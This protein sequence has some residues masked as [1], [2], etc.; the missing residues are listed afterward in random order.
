MKSPKSGPYRMN[1]YPYRSR[2]A[3]EKQAATPNRRDFQT[4]CSRCPTL[5]SVCPKHQVAWSALEPSSNHSN[6]HPSRQCESRNMPGLWH[7][8]WHGL[9][10]PTGQALQNESPSLLNL[11]RKKHQAS[12]SFKSEGVRHALRALQNENHGCPNL[13]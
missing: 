13:P 10:F 9:S 12:S 8:C 4:C 3:D 2:C 5:D 6:R 11:Q 7:F 1:I